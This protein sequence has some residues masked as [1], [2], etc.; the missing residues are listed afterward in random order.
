MLVLE[1]AT[2]PRE[3]VCGD[4]LTPRGVKALVRMGVRSRA[5]GWLR[6]KGLR[7]IGGGVRLELPWPELSSYPGYGL[8]RTRLDFDETL[9]RTAQRRAPGC[10]RAS[11]DRPVLDDRTAA[12]SASRAIPTAAPDEVGML[13]GPWWSPPT[14]TPP[15][16]RWPWACTSGTTGRWA[17][18]SGRTTQ[19]AAR[20]RLSRILAG[21]VGREHLL[22]GYG[23]IFGMG[24]GTT[25]VGLGLLNT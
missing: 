8:V 6:N 12:S 23:W 16:C 15:G 7:I 10:S 2:F 9:A 5:G 25:N 3:K 20:R 13:P 4:G 11:R 17:S 14:A 1:K 21:A 19:P 24:D 22:P 18:P